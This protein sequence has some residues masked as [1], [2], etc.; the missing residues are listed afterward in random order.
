MHPG[1]AESW[2]RLVEV[3]RSGLIPVYFEVGT[4]RI[5]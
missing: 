2:T 4:F 5:C 3:E 1:V